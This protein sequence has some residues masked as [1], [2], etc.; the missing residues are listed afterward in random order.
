L[1][2]SDVGRG[3]VVVYAEY[4]WHWSEN[5]SL[6]FL[7]RPKRVEVCAGVRTDCGQ[8]LMD[9]EE[10]SSHVWVEPDRISFDLSLRRLDGSGDEECWKGSV[11]R[12]SW[13]A[14]GEEE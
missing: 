6:F 2:R 5:D 3:G 11:L 1:V 12:E 4:S 14:P 10:Q 8:Y 7:L 13:R 9:V